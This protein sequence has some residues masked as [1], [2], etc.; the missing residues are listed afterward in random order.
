LFKVIFFEPKLMDYLQNNYAR[1]PFINV[2]ANIG[3]MQFEEVNG[4]IRVEFEQ[5]VTEDNRDYL[6]S[7]YF[8]GL[9]M[10]T[11]AT[12]VYKGDYFFDLVFY[13]YK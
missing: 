7:L 8:K 1:Q 6:F 3:S 13:E 5:E 11:E 4:K 12:M 9:R 10:Q 2:V